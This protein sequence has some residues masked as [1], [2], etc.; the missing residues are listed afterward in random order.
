MNWYDA[1]T[2]FLQVAET[3]SFIGAAR[4]LEVTNSLITKRIQ[5]LEHALGCTLFVR[6]TRRVKLTDIGEF[7][8]QRIKPLADEWCTIKTQVLDFKTQPQGDINLCLPTSISTIGAFYDCLQTFLNQFT[9]IKLNVTH[10]NQAVDL[11]TKNID[12]LIGSDSYVKDP[13]ITRAKKLFDFHYQCYAAPLYIQKNGKPERIKEL[14]DHNCLIFNNNNHWQFKYE[15]ITVSGNFFTD[16]GDSLL[17]ACLNGL[18]IARA[19]DFMVTE[20]VN[21][22]K[23]IPL[24]PKDKLSNQQLSAFYLQRQYQPHKIKLLL[25]HLQ[26]NLSNSIG[27][28]M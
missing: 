22:E 5:W 4:Q 18:G 11:V 6:T 3:H 13:T 24:I 12:V 2:S 10:T 14:V 21:T 25:E 16:A 15:S 26:E 1:L 27:D 23:L 7:L 19:P 9:H 28:Y 8:Y 17:N 20:L